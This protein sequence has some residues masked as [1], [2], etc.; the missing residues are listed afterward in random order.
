MARKMHV[1]AQADLRW[2]TSGCSMQERRNKIL[3]TFRPMA[4]IQDHR[5]SIPSPDA[6]AREERKISKQARA[7]N[8]GDARRQVAQ[9]SFLQ[10]SGGS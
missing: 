6:S 8:V 2:P 4:E 1:A 5:L 9:S 3:N 10:T 7:M